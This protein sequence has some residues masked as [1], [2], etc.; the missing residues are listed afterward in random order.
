MA[1]ASG[2]LYWV[3]YAGK[4]PPDGGAT[5][6]GTVVSVAL[7]GGVPSTL[8]AGLQNTGG[9]VV[10]ATH[11]FWTTD[12]GIVSAG[13]DGGGRQIL[14][15]TTDA[16]PVALLQSGPALYWVSTIFQADGGASSTIMRMAK[17]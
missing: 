4:T 15:P 8:A 14:V 12:E 16:V 1:A 3:T 5:P 9:L 10:D 11:V 6:A 17:P 2:S 13:L 7:D